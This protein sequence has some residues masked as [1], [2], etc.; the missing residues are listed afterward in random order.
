M[1]HLRTKVVAGAFALLLCASTLLSLAAVAGAE[2][3]EAR[4]NLP[5]LAE[6]ASWAA[7]A[8]VGNSVYV[9]GGTQGY[10][11]DIPPTLD[12]VQVYDLMTGE[13]TNGTHML[14]GVTGAG[15]GLGPD[16]KIYIAGGWNE[17]D[18]SYYQH[19]QIYDPA[20]DNWTLASEDVPEPIGRSASAM[21]P[22]GSLYVF[23]GG[24]TS[25][26]T[27]IY[28]TSSDTWKYGAQ[29][30]VFGLDGRAVFY[31]D[32][33]VIVFGGSYGGSS[34]GVRIYNP[35]ADSWSLGT[36]SPISEAYAA[37]ALASNGLV[38]LFGG[39]PSGSPSD[40]SP[41]STVMRYSVSKDVWDTSSATL[42]SGRDSSLALFTEMMGEGHIV[43]L[44]G[45]DGAAGVATVD[46]F[47]ISEIA[48]TELIQISSPTDKSIVSGVVPVDVEMVNSFTPFVQIDLFVDGVLFETRTD[49]LSVTFLWNTSS[50]SDGSVHT[51]MAIGYNVDGSAVED[52]VSVTVSNL[53]FEQQIANIEAAVADL[54]V[55][56][57]TMN[58]TVSELQA[59]LVALQAALGMLMAGSNA[60]FANLQTQLDNMQ[61]QVDRIESKADTAGTYSI[62]ITILVVIVLILLA[63]NFIMSRRET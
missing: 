62:I 58:G 4:V 41:V 49:A 8:I 10:V 36:P 17:S 63:L 55:R 35:V 57:N 33:T 11:V 52:S 19:V 38:Y 2:P 16:G 47:A 3:V 20:R 30:P 61:T 54:Q 28:N 24:W 42:S 18:G 37:P 43:V 9:I 40:V 56:I 53:S 50:L 31:N 1:N 5:P 21:S 15:Y 39:A 48:G 44:G 59:R 14:K 12:A 32:T 29:Q 22:D 34:S 60:T 26:V 13:T 25:N 46:G 45:F 27:L 23:G 6:P 51:L 7:G